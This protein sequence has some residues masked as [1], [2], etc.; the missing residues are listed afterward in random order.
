MQLHCKIIRSV[1]YKQRKITIYRA[2]KR[3]FKSF[4]NIV[5]KFLNKS[6]GVYEQIFNAVYFQFS[7]CRV[8][9]GKQ[10]IFSSTPAPVS[11]FIRL[12]FPVFVYPTS[13]ITFTPRFER[14]SLTRVR[15]VDNSS[16]RFSRYS[17]RYLLCLLSVSSCVSSG[18]L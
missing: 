9:S 7:R 3:R 5:R 12:D 8:E 14:L 16:M 18:P 2:F 11:T 13:A 10:C 15:R 4:N 6:D 17:M 1:G